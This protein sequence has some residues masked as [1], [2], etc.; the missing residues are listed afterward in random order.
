MMTAAVDGP[1]EDFID[2]LSA[3]TPYVTSLA[4]LPAYVARAAYAAMK[5]PH[6][7]NQSPTTSNQ[8]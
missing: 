5:N 1:I 3:P 2:T 4:M 8:S 6:Q 7:R